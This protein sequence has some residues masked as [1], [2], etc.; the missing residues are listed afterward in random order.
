M[1][2]SCPTSR[3]VDG[4]PAAR[5]SVFRRMAV[6]GAAHPD[7]RREARALWRRDPVERAAA[8]LARVQELP[9]HPDP[10]GFGGDWV[11][12]PCRTLVEGGDCDCLTVLVAA[13]D[14]A[15]GL[16][17]RIGWLVQPRAALDHVAAQVY[18][19]RAW[20]FQ[21]VTVRGAVLGEG[22]HEAVARLGSASHVFGE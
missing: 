7:V 1:K 9:Y 17:W 6:E 19:R 3:V 4:T 13:L 8:L 20:L 10:A 11:R 18:L 16:T 14:H 12:P 2:P 15:S 22:P 5:L 21:E